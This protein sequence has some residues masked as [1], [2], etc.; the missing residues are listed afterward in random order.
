MAWAI[1]YR[2]VHMNGAQR[3]P[4]SRFGFMA[5]AAPIP[6]EFPQD[7]IDYAVSLGAAEGVPPPTREGKRAIKRSK[8]A[9]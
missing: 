7:F 9:E 8:R 3:K 1:F 5:E 4:K 2:T 6:Q